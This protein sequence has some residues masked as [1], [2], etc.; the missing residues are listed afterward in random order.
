MRI[1]FSIV[2]LLVVLGV[3]AMLSKQQLKAVPAISAPA[4]NPAT[5]PASSEPVTTAVLPA[6]P[7]QPVAGGV[8]PQ[9]MQIQQQIKAALDAA[10]QP[11][12]S[13]A[14]EKP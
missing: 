10:A 14:D 8:A 7:Q 6:I 3:V 12:R 4:T 11:L 2:S 5:N 9:A 1:I 13:P